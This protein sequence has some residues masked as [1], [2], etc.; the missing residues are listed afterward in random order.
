MIYLDS[1]IRAGAFTDTDLRLATVIA[2]MAAAAIERAETFQRLAQQEKLASMGTLMASV[3]HELRNPLA[4]ILG[5]TELLALEHADDL[6]TQGLL[7]EARRCQKLVQ[8]FLRLSRQEP[9]EFRPLYIEEVLNTAMTAIRSEA[10]RSGVSLKISIEPSLPCIHGNPGHLSQVFLNLLSNAV[11]AAES[12]T[13]GEVEVLVER[14]G[15]SIRIS[16]ADNGP[17]LPEGAVEKLFSPFFTT[18]PDDR[19]TGL[20]LSIVQRI[21]AEHGGAVTAANDP[22]GGAVFTVLLPLPDKA[23]RAVG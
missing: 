14:F 19:G 22:D 20:G 18:K 12:V 9:A 11:F 10:G 4:A 13:F 6:L 2:G 1:S 3:M 23:D 21:V 5:S 7:E 8:D 16:I 17:G 15:P